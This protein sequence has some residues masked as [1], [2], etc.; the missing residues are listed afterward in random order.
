[1]KGG[2]DEELSSVRKEK[3]QNE[4]LVK[5]FLVN[6]QQRIHKKTSYKVNSDESYVIRVPMNGAKDI[7]HEWREDKKG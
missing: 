6:A 7:P 5:Q 4:K 2:G 1:M 3:E